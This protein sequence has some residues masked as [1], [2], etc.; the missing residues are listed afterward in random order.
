VITPIACEAPGAVLGPRLNGASTMR[1]VPGTQIERACGSGDLQGEYF[2]SFEVNKDY[3]DDWQSA[4]LRVA[5]LGSDGEMRALE[6]PDKRHFIA[7]LFQP[8]LSSS[9]DRPHPIIVGYLRACM[10]PRQSSPV[11]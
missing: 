6:L 8:Q 9:F 4:G 11:S 3:L 1:V 5:A 2:C 7:T 10:A